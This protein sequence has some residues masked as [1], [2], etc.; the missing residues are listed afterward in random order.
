MLAATASVVRSWAAR[1][2]ALLAAVIRVV[3]KP[4]LAYASGDQPLVT[5]TANWPAPRWS[6]R[7]NWPLA[8]PQSP[9]RSPIPRPRRS[10][11][12]STR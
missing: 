5:P 1:R 6:K 11:S 4:V 12:D 3:A 10:F 7:S 8:T 2:K 9:L